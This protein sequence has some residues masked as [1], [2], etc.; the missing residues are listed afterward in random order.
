MS[1]DEEP[2]KKPIPQIEKGSFKHLIV[3]VIVFTVAA[4]IIFPIGDWLWDLIFTHNGFEFSVGEHIL[5][6]I[7]FGVIMGTVFWYFDRRSMKSTKKK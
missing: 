6:P 1:K 2:K 7:I 4:L 5:E 3:Q